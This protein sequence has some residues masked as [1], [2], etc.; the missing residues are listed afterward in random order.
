MK[1]AVVDYGLAN[2]R[3]VVNAL[4]CFDVETYVAST[5]EA[6]KNADKILLPGVGAFNAGMQ[7]LRERGHVD[8]LNDLVLHEKKPCLGICLGF[9][10]LFEGSEEGSEL[11]LGWIKGKVRCFNRS[12]TKVPHIGW[13]ELQINPKSRLLKGLE[14]PVDVYFVH[15]YYAPS[16]GE[17]FET[18]SAYCE[19]SVK[20]VVAVRKKIFLVFN[21]ILKNHS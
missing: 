3:S 8:M 4:N 11:G 6:L 15:S 17:A 1:I 10:F 12:S 14:S 19:Y 18:A 20:Y 5:G 2:I 21:F 9:Q 7:G 16:E 13:N